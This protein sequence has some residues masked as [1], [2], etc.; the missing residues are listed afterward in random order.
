MVALSL[1][2]IGTKLF[3]DYKTNN[4]FGSGVTACYSSC[5]DCFGGSAPRI[6]QSPSGPLPAKRDIHRI[7]FTLTCIPLEIPHHIVRLLRQI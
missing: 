1:V 6:R 2:L 4:R 7:R 5:N 3:A